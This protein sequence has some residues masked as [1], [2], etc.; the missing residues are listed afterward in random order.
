MSKPFSK[1]DMLERDIITWLRNDLD[2]EP[3][4]V[5]VKSSDKGAEIYYDKLKRRIK[6]LGLNMTVEDWLAMNRIMLIVGNGRTSR[7]IRASFSEQ[8]LRIWEFHDRSAFLDSH[9]AS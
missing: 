2:G 3:M 4:Y 7:Q 6:R 1:N 9:E 5:Q 8:M